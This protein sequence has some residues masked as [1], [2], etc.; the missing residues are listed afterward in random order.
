MIHFQRKTLSSFYDRYP[1]IA[2]SA[3][4]YFL[5]KIKLLTNELSTCVFFLNTRL[6]IRKTKCFGARE[7]APDPRGGG[8]RTYGTPFISAKW[9]K[10]VSILVRVDSRIKSLSNQV[11]PPFSL[12]LVSK[13][14]TASKNIPKF[15]NQKYSWNIFHFLYI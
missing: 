9:Q 12:K 11:K 3:Q 15:K 10:N 1:H 6:W 14:S 4:K 5:K 7:S 13:F 2:F 8:L